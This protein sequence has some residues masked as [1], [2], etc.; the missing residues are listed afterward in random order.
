M[1]V[2]KSVLRC[3]NCG[4]P[5]VTGGIWTHRLWM[6]RYSMCEVCASIKQVVDEKLPYEAIGGLVF[7]PKLIP[8]AAKT[9]GP[10]IWAIR[11]DGT[12]VRWQEYERFYGA[13]KGPYRQ[14][15]NDTLQYVPAGVVKPKEGRLN[16]CT[17]K[18]CLD[19]LTCYWYQGVEDYNEVP[20]GIMKGV[21]ECPSYMDKSIILKICQ[22]FTY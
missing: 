21:E 11:K 22:G 14:L 15:F 18:G 4:A 6:D 2:K 12:I 13:A 8:M 9:R 1:G 16:A 7:A 10:L 5:I 3:S 20:E 17:N 19:R